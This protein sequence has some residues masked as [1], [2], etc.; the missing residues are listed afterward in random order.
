MESIGYADRRDVAL[1]R[2]NELQDETAEIMNMIQDPNVIQQL[3]QDK[4]ANVQFLKDNFGVSCIVT[5]FICLPKT[6]NALFC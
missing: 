1:K 4:I 2:F 6:C 3:K 5:G